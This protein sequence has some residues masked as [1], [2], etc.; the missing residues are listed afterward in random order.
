MGKAV[1]Q[2]NAW[3][4]LEHLVSVVGRHESNG[5]EGTNK[6]IIRHIRTLVHDERIS[7]KWGHPE[8]YKAVEHYVN[9]CDNS[10][11]G[12]IPLQARFG[13][14]VLPYL[15]VDAHLTPQAFTSA[16]VKELDKDLKLI[17]ELS[18]KYQ[19]NLVAHR[20]KDVDPTK[21]N[22]YQPGDFVLRE[23]DRSQPH[24]KIGPPYTGPW[25]VEYQKGNDVTCR[26]VVEDTVHTFQ[27]RNVKIFAGTQEQAFKAALLDRN[28]YRVKVIHSNRGDPEVRTTMEFYIE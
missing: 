11:S 19:D 15:D 28:Q 7:H 20:L 3:L 13:T 22:T 17:R 21:Q 26:H 9:K 2:H 16:Y 4:G 5:V 14:D 8:V 23:L 10:E 27:V 24:N 6:Q 12:A 1:T 25:K 18:Q